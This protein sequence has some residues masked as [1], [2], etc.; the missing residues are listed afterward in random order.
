MDVTNRFVL[1][2]AKRFASDHPGA[3]ILDYGCGAGAVVTAARGTGLDVC[4]VDEKF[5]TVGR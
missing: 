2:F 1:D 5:G 4:G 3:R